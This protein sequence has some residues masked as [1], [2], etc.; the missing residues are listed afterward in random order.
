MIQHLI[1]KIRRFSKFTIRL[2]LE[3]RDVDS[4]KEKTFWRKTNQVQESEKRGEG[5]RSTS[6]LG[7]PQEVASE[8]L[9]PP[10]STLTCLCSL[11]KAI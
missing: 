10:A 4:L 9:S 1:D 6:L 7:D 8:P 11:E 5:G 2:T 3:D